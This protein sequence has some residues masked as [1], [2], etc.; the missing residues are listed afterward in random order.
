[1]SF[2]DFF[3]KA[4][5]PN[6]DAAEFERIMKSEV[7]SVIIDVRTQREFDH[8]HIPDALHINVQDV[9]FSHKIDDMD[10]DA[11]YLVYCRSGRRSMLA[12]R[13][14]HSKGF[15]NVYNLAGGILAWPSEVVQ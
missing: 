6:I 3:K 15:K 5:I 10:K 2:L 7:N 13:S 1:M 11:H 8:G 9:A 12:C 14:M 4:D